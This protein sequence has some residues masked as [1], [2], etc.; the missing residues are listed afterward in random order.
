MDVGVYVINV[1]L[2]AHSCDAHSCA[3]TICATYSAYVFFRDPFIL[4]GLP[5]IVVGLLTC[6]HE[7]ATRCPGLR[8]CDG[9]CNGLKGKEGRYR[10]STGEGCVSW[11]R[12]EVDLVKFEIH[13][14]SESGSKRE[15]L[16]G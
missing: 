5:C 10:A 9:P 7:D 16:R 14:Q 4:K 11:Q 12:S 13:G 8:A 2:C 3:N 15:E 1:Q 6:L